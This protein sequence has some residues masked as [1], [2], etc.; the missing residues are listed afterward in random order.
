VIALADSE[1]IE[2]IVANLLSN[3]I[4]CTEPGGAI[5][6]EVTLDK[7]GDKAVDEAVLDEATLDEPVLDDHGAEC[8]IQVR[9]TGIGIP[10]EA[11]PHLFDRFYQV[12]SS[13][14]RAREGMGIG[15]ALAR[16]LARLHGGDLD[17]TSTLGEG[18]TFTLTLP[19]SDHA[20]LERPLRATQPEELR[21]RVEEI[22]ELTRRAETPL[23]AGQSEESTATVADRRRLLVVD[24]NEDLRAYLR[25]TLERRYEVLAAEDGE[26][27]LALAL[28]EL[29]DLVIADVMM[30]RMDGFALGR[31]LRDDPQAGGIPLLYLT[32][33]AGEAD[34]LEGFASGAV[35]YI[36]KPFNSAML[37][38]RV[39]ALLRQQERLRVRLQAESREGRNTGSAGTSRHGE[40]ETKLRAIIQANLHEDGFGVEQLAFAAAASRPTLFRRLKEE[41]DISPSK[42]LSDVRLER[43]ETLLAAGEGNVS[44]V[45]YAVGFI[46]LAGFSRA[47]KR[48][49]GV[50]PASRLQSS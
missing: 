28:R 26:A 37:L 11:L 30:P 32:A 13:S 45:A 50:A 39:E 15:L 8:R 2:R 5:E 3:A 23:D 38:A 18:A 49:F 27:G 47:Y 10:A 35:G 12:D 36:T 14:T 41:A 7:A 31:A 44:E 43:A 1:Q 19:T 21:E 6:V 42:L 33:R 4:K 34:A 22:A 17:V 40:Y 9:D 48:R 20:H 24:D 25:R 16:E 29:P 46:S